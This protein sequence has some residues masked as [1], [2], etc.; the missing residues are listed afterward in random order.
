MKNFGHS[1]LCVD[2]EST[3]LRRYHECKTYVHAPHLYIISFFIAFCNLEFWVGYLFNDPYFPTT[4][5]RVMSS[6]LIRPRSSRHTVSLLSCPKTRSPFT[7]SGTHGHSQNANDLSPTRFRRPLTALAPFS[8][9][10]QHQIYISQ[11]IN[12]YFNLTFE[13]WYVERQAARLD[14][15][16]SHSGAVSFLIGDFQVVSTCTSRKTPSSSLPRFALCG[17]RPEPESVEGNQL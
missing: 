17:D 5:I 11:S 3:R 12:P 9:P 6:F 15:F 2:L 1:T 16:S 7:T 13:D 8:S 4:A 10:P 14:P